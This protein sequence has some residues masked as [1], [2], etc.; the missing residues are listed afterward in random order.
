MSTVGP[1]CPSWYTSPGP[2][3]TGAPGG[4]V[5][6][7]DTLRSLLTLSDRG[8]TG[9]LRVQAEGHPVSLFLMD[10]HLVATHADDDALSMLDALAAAGAIPEARANQLRHLTP[11]AMAVLQRMGGDPYVGLMMKAVPEGDLK[12]AFRHRLIE[13]VARFV[14][15][16]ATPLFEPDELPW[17]DNIQVEHDTFDFICEVTGLTRP[18]ALQLMPSHDLDDREV[19]DSGVFDLRDLEAALRSQGHRA[20]S[21]SV[22]A[23]IAQG[24]EQEIEDLHT[25]DIAYEELEDHLLEDADLD[26]EDEAPPVTPSEPVDP[27]EPALEETFDEGDT[28]DDGP[29]PAPLSYSAADNSHHDL[30][31]DAFADHD[32]DVYAFADHDDDAT[33]TY[34]RS[35]PPALDV[36]QDAAET[37]YDDEDEPTAEDTVRFSHAADAPGDADLPDAGPEPEADAPSEPVAPEEPPTSEVALAVHDAYDNGGSDEP[38]ASAPKAKKPV[39][40]KAASKPK[41]DG[42]DDLEAFEG[43]EDDRRGGGADGTFV[44]DTGH[45]D[46]VELSE[47]AVEPAATFGA[48]TLS[49]ADVRQKISVANEVLAS[50]AQAFEANG[51]GSGAETIQLLIDG[52][53]REFGPLLQDVAVRRNGTLPPQEILANLRRRP[54]AEQRRLIHDGLLDLVDRAL[55]RAADELEDDL[56][57]GVLESTA[58]YR[59]RFGL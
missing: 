5:E 33:P 58:G 8:A 13:N 37:V 46:T 26:E 19:F 25:E 6:A 34:K 38:A 20:L 17:V 48:P 55:D 28:A 22:V 10:G 23:S 39:R 53:P 44:T 4:R 16:P 35:A 52:R 56:L 11:D 49:D 27:G 41:K 18:D 14:E 24:E 1:V 12:A 51:T 21:E 31:D 7:T 32:L 54:M 2:A 40:S 50:L 30:D 47:E 59:Q 9:C 29:G 36:D 57:D 42:L 3:R 15:S 43:S 45:L